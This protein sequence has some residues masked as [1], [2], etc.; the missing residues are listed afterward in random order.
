METSIKTSSN[1]LLEKVKAFSLH[2]ENYQSLSPQI[3]RNKQ[4]EEAE[5]IS[6][7][8]EFLVFEL[9][10]NIYCEILQAIIEQSSQQNDYEIKEVLLN[11]VANAM[12]QSDCIKKIDLSFLIKQIDQLKGD[13]LLHALDIIGLSRNLSY[14]EVIRRFLKHSNLEVRETAAMA[15]SE[16]ESFHQPG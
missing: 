1:T 15:L 7:D 12:S 4:L 11:S 16:I 3:K 10:E 2:G 6:D 8:L 14:V 13:C 9:E 5:K